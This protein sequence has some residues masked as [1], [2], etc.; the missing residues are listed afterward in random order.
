MNYYRYLPLVALCLGSLI[1]VQAQV[2]TDPSAWPNFDCRGAQA[3]AAPAP[4]S[5]QQ[6]ATARLQAQVPGVVVDF[7]DPLGTPAFVRA[8]GLLSQPPQDAEKWPPLPPGLSVALP[9]VADLSDPFWSLKQF[10][11]TN[12][13]L[14]GFDAGILAA[15]PLSRDSQAPAYGARTV[16]WA[17]Q[18]NGIPVFEGILIANFSGN[19]LVSVSSR[20]VPNTSGMSVLGDVSVPA[21]GAVALA[22]RNI[23][24]AGADASGFAATGAPQGAEE[25]QRFAGAPVLD[26]A[27]VSLVWLPMDRSTL[28]LCWRV[29]LTGRS[30]GLLFQV[31]IDSGSGEP[32]VRH[33]WTSAAA[34]ATYLIFDQG[35]PAPMLPGLSTPAT[36][37]AAVVAQNAVTLG[38]VTTNASPLGWVETNANSF[39]LT[40][41][42][43]GNNVDA[44]VYWFSDN[45]PYGAP[46]V[47]PNIPRPQGTLTNG[48]VV[49]SGPAFT[50]DFSQFPTNGPNASASVV[51]GFFW[52]NWMHDVLYELGFTEAAGNYQSDNLGRGG[53]NAVAGDPVRMRVQ[54]G[55]ANDP[56]ATWS[57]S[58]SA[59][60]Q[61][62]G[63]GSVSV[64]LWGDNSTNRDGT[65]DTSVLLHEY[66][67]L[68]SRRLV[69]L[70]AGIGAYQAEA[71]AEGWSDFYA[72]SLLSTAGAD[73]NGTYQEAA[74]AAYRWHTNAFEQNY[75]FGVRPYP[76]STDM[77][78][79]PQTLLDITDDRFHDPHP[80]IPI[81]L[82]FNPTNDLL[83][84]NESHPVGEVWCVALWEARANL[85]QEYG[86]T[87]GNWL[88]LQ[89]VTDAMKLGPANPN[90]LQGRDAV[91]L[92][93]SVRT[94]GQNALGIWAAF[95]KRGMGYDAT[96]A[97]SN[98]NPAGIASAV[99]ESFAIPPFY[100]NLAAS[101]Y[102]S[103]ACDLDG[104][105]YVGSA[106]GLHA[107][108]RDGTLRWSFN[109]NYA[110]NSSPAIGPGGIVYV[111]CNDSN[112]YAIASSGAA[113]WSNNLAAA[114]FSS[115]AVAA[116]GTIYVGSSNGQFYA[117]RAD[118]SGKWTNSIG[119]AI[120]SSPA[121]ALD[122]TVYVG[123][124][125]SSGNL[126]A[127]NPTNG[128]ALSG[129]PVT[130]SGGV[131]SS[132]AI[133][134]DGGVYVGGLDGKVYGFTAS[135]AA[136]SGW[137]FTTGGAVYSSPAVSSN[138]T[139]YVG[140]SD[141]LLY[142]INSSGSTNWTFRTGS[143]VWCS[144]AL[145][146]NGTVFVGSYDAQFYAIS[147]GGSSRWAYPVGS[148][149]L[150]SPVIGMDGRIYFGSLGGNL[151]VLPSGT[152]FA[153]AP[154]GMFRQNLRHSSNVKT[155][156]LR[157]GQV[158]ANGNFVFDITGPA[159]ATCGV[160]VTTNF[161]SWSSL[162]TVT[163]INGV[164][165]VQT[166]TN[167]SPLGFYRATLSN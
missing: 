46:M 93:D 85:I 42:T 19:G 97:P 129:W 164:A 108:S 4:L 115:P 104:T 25:S 94:G 139:V 9:P 74:F 26:E 106:S 83:F 125:A 52:C 71:M 105:I 128:A 127:L 111:G 103:P 22:A 40:N 63:V 101:I 134:S 135:G 1:N 12:A 62:G 10:L 45:A 57:A 154:W 69:G 18:F 7:D 98:V 77:T 14:F 76:C 141:G 136:R 120:S 96:N 78:R 55:T 20:F 116:D 24:E 140:S 48:G 58:G 41:T 5:A 143:N 51:S 91:L 167:N 95:A 66:T 50:A 131:Y 109:T 34:P 161:L 65:L 56:I 23:G 122:G 49:F 145:G 6:A 117:F 84:L 159:G 82:M 38:A 13:G 33:C 158:A 151:Y 119:A 155:L 88:M 2:P 132:P 121:I 157:P 35:S 37:Q 90:F 102:S 110:F 11:N 165:T 113:L 142:A 114:V 32:L 137:P 39:G 44:H 21:A 81:S 27:K 68:L 73:I 60:P 160:G 156:I 89:L 150:S 152:S 70:G 144:P 36:N 162:T 15:A 130:V 47:L 107:L 166:S 163:L 147:P 8:S 146:R 100:T 148:P 118:G 138:G 61:D 54:L 75:Y 43:F 112:L 153:D 87:N 29:V 3:A 126:Y 92:A 59:T 17:Q 30:T 99:R 67:H 133:G 124:M 31:L 80:G 28:R 149:V 64:T 16:A 86:F 72:L 123:S 53:T 79:S